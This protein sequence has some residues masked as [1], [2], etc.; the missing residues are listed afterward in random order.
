MHFLKRNFLHDFIN[1]PT[2]HQI[3]F[4]E[5][6]KHQRYPEIKAL[7]AEERQM[8]FGIE[9]ETVNM[10][11]ADHLSTI[12]TTTRL[13]KTEDTIKLLFNI[14]GINLSPNCWHYL[15]AHYHYLRYLE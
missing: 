3:F 9:P 8:E 15:A 14:L 6:I 2:T 13:K 7:L 1:S 12:L 4:K 10:L 11:V 5:L